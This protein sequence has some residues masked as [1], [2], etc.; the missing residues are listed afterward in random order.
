MNKNGIKFSPLNEKTLKT[1]SYVFCEIN[2]TTLSSPPTTSTM[3]SVL[4]MLIFIYIY[5]YYEL[6]ILYFN[7]FSF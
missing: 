2:P 6:H 4:L 3:P 5:I 7:I 1:Y